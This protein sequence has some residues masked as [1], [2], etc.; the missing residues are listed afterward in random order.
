MFLPITTVRRD[1]RGP[2]QVSTRTARP[3]RRCSPGLVEDWSSLQVPGGAAA[4]VSSQ[5]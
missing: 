3:Q 2:C 4:I 1:G 5:E